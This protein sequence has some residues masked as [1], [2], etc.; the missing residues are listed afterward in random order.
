LPAD[1]PARASRSE[2][3]TI[4]PDGTG[5]RVLTNNQV[6]DGD[7]SFSPDGANIAFE[8]FRDGFSEA[9]RMGADGS[10]PFRLTESGNNEDRSTNW[11][12][13]GTKIAFHSTR[14]SASSG[15]NI[16]P[17]G[18]PFEIYVMDADGSN[19]VRITNNLSRDTFP[20]WSPDGSRLT[21][22]TN[23]D[24]DFEIY[25][26]NPDGTDPQR[27]TNSLTEDAH[28]TW[29]PDGR[30][31]TFHSRRAGGLEIFRQNAD[32]SGEATQV[33]NAGADDGFA[34]FPV[35]S[36]DGTRIAFNGNLAPEPEDF[37]VYHVNAVDGSDVQ[38]VTS[39]P[40]FD[41]RCDWET[42][43]P[44]APPPAPQPPPA[45]A[46]PAAGPVANPCG[47]PGGVGYPNPAKLRVSR[48][49]VL[50]GDRRLDV[51]AP[52]T[53]RADRDVSVTFFADGRLDTFGAQVSEASTLL[54]E[55]R[56]SRQITRGQARLGTGIVLLDYRGDED[57]RPQFVRLRAASQR[58]ELEVDE[59]S[60]IGDRLSARGSVTERAEGIVRFRFSYVDERGG[61]RVH[62]ARAEIQDDGAW[63][64][65]GERV[66]LQL[67]RCGGYLS[68]QFTGYF[69]RRIR[70]EQLAYQ[71]DPGQTRRP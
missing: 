2:V 24:G 48:A 60:L 28:S 4:N 45:P 9:Y 17:G 16:P 63:E 19:E 41:G 33:T 34:F 6:R 64:L 44:P 27:V 68:V 49:R 23:R 25:T 47:T 61:A 46:P 56:I 54:D 43:Q 13:D 39:S 62:E 38:R 32:G 14:D 37:E 22:T 1:A 11:S 18:D 36:P 40:G 66:P 7:P 65:E 59:I 51:L 35:W 31:L 55:I 58:A 21:F 26:M 3:F 71:L 8:T 15:G 5:E 57:T 12:P 67:A 69:E 70:G 53:S 30:Q 42:V 29:S 20:Q 10:N 52:I 50:E